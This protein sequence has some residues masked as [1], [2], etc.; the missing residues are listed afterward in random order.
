M[1]EKFFLLLPDFV[2]Y[3]YQNSEDPS[4]IR[5][6]PLPGYSLDVHEQ[7]QTF[8]LYCQSLNKEFF[9]KANSDKDFQ[10]FEL[11]CGTKTKIQTAVFI[12]LLNLCVSNPF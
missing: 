1:N 5:A 6:I 12:S 8:K 9:F 2:L 11:L 7:I 4:A 10:R 3:V